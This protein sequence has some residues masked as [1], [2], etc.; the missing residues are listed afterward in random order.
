MFLLSKLLPVLLAGTV[1]ANDSG[2]SLHRNHARQTVKYAPKVPPL[3]TPWTSKVG[4]NPWP[5]YPRP[6]LERS[7]WQ[8]LN[9][10]W[11]YQNAAGL[12]AVQAPP[13]GQALANEVLI[14][15][16]LESALSGNVVP[17]HWTSRE[18]DAMQESKET[19]LFILGS[20]RP[21]RSPS[22]GNTRMCF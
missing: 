11:Q 10:I 19:I 20:P 22:S 3:D 7:E 18:V 1:L 13:F 16:C 21:S 9:G 4:T 5:E 2:E 6:Q 8:N 15:S 17:L 14:P 12:E